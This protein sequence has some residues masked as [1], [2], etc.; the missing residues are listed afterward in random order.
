MLHALG[1]TQT[2][3]G[4]TFAVDRTTISNILK[5]SYGWRAV[6]DIFYAAVAP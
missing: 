5:G 6:F 2:L 1:A 3:L 4:H